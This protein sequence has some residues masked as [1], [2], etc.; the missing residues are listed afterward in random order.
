MEHGIKIHVC[1][2]IMGTGKTSAAINKM[3]YETGKKF[4]FLTQT[5][6]ETHRIRKGCWTRGFKIPNN[7]EGSKLNHLHTLLKG[8]CNIATTHALFYYYTEE[9]LEYIR[10]ENYCLVLDEV[11]DIVKFLDVTNDD[12]V[13]LIDARLVEVEPGTNRVVWLRDGYSGVWNPLKREIDTSFVTY[14]DG[15][16]L[17]WMMPIEMF[18]AFKEILILT[19]MFKAQY[20]YYYFQLHGIE[21]EYV[22]VNN[23][24][25][26]YLFTREV[27]PT[28]IKLPTIHVVEEDSLNHIGENYYA[29]S[30]KW[31]KNERGDRTELIQTLK[32]NLYNYFTNKV[33]GRS[34]DRLWASYES[35][36]KTLR[37]KGFTKR[38]IAFNTR[39][40][41]EYS[42]CAYLAY[43]VNVFPHVDTQTYFERR[44]FAIDRDALATSDM[45]Q[46][47]WRSRL[48]KG[49]DVWLY[50]PSR[51]MRELL[52]KWIDEVSLKEI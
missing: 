2:A 26:K 32:N 51:R 13:S 50:L 22:G 49:Q 9:T 42:N 36:E 23:V 47:L 3:N 39:A 34:E 44:G 38:H 20:Q 28:K 37:G 29:L 17:V 31:H 6:D 52:Y 4:I 7:S 45:V 35:T 27:T 5:I 14:E 46:W 19:Y 30:S 11:I 48:R 8:K 41:N 12:I 25:G 16:L 43:L 10:N 21:I 18:A 33:E 24:N 15:R 1:D 40:T